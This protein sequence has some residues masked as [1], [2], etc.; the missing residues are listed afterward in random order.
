MNA[1]AP[2][3]K[4]AYWYFKRN[5]RAKLF[6]LF[7]IASAVPLMILGYMS[8]SKSSEEI[9]SQIVQYGQSSITQLQSQLDSYSRQ[10]KSTTRYIYA[11]LLDPINGTLH[12]GDPQNF[13]SYVNQKNF[14]R[15]LDAH[16]TEETSGIYLIGPTDTYFGSPQIDVKQLK[17]QA[18]WQAIPDHYRGEYWT[19]LHDSSYYI[20][21][22]LNIPKQVVGLVFPVQSQYGYLQNSRIVVEMDASKLLDAFDT[23]ENTLHSFITIRDRDG[24]LIYQSAN[25]VK[26]RADDLVWN[27]SIESSGWSI[28]VRTLYEPVYQSTIMIR[29]FTIALIGLAFVFVLLISYF[30]SS[31][32]TRRIMSLKHKMQLVGIGQL[33]SRIDMDTEDELGRLG[34]SFNKMV[35]QIQFLIEEVQHKEQLKK[36][37]QLQAFHYQINPHLLL[38]TLNMIQWQAKLKSDAEIQSMIHY[39]IKVLEGNLVITEELIPLEKELQTVEYYLKIQEVRYGESFQYRIDS[40][41]SIGTCLIPRMTLQPLL[42]NTFFHGFEDGEGTIDITVKEEGEELVLTLVDDGAGIEAERLE[43]LLLEQQPPARLGTGGLGCYNVDQKFKLHFGEMYGMHIQ[44]RI[45]AGTKITIHWPKT[46]PDTCPQMYVAA[47]D[48]SNKMTGN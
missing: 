34:T 25:R 33:Q 31:R 6:L 28:E 18:W 37:A 17:Q 15:F 11:Y 2:I 22:N 26:A 36:E 35:E 5:L 3:W 46:E 45:G 27:R 7:F 42:E 29:Y 1:R 38:N 4:R 32:I 14:N 20:S 13:A 23:L 40:D 41:P 47:A 8:Y 21:R 30:F 39:L 24:R 48:G 19:G 9:Q 12:P 16:K 43:T 44:S 10:M